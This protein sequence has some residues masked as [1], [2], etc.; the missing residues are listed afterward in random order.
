MK[1]V[2]IPDSLILGAVQGL[3]EFIPISSSGHLILVQKIFGLKDRGLAF[4]AFLHL[5][6][7]LATLI[8]FR[9]DWLKILKET[10]C[11]KIFWYIIIATLPAALIGIFLQDI[12]ATFFRDILWVA[13][14]LI[15]TSFVFFLAEKYYYL[16]INKK[17]LDKLNWKDA[18]IIGFS[19]IFALLPGVSRSGITICAGM[20]RSL[21]RVEA[22]RFSFLMAT[23]IIFGAGFMETLNLL[24]TSKFN[25][26]GLEAAGGFLTSFIAGFLSI[27]FLLSFLKTHRLYIFALYLFIIGIIL[28]ILQWL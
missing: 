25:T 12:I 11:R 24:S 1:I 21:R 6:T 9:G 26:L 22:T 4:D 5:G 18:L 13:L 8:Y 7:L 3:T 28:L 2:Q 19:Q 17:S 16:K 15:L 14:F 20:F 27:K 23:L 10:A